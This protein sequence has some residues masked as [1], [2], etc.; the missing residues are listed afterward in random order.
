MLITYTVTDT[1]RAGLVVKNDEF[2]PKTLLRRRVKMNERKEFFAKLSAAE[3]SVNEA[4]TAGDE[5]LAYEHSKEMILLMLEGIT[6]EDF[7]KFDIYEMKELAEALPE[8]MQ[9]GGKAAKKNE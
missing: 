3:K 6:Q 9:N 5:D 1:G 7:E 8:L 4:T 2:G